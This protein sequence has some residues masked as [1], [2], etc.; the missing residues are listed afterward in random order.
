MNRNI[1]IVIADDH[2]IVR[3]GL[4]MML[5][6]DGTMDVVGEA[7]TG[8][9]AIELAQLHKPDVMTMDIGFPDMNGV[10]V[11]REILAHNPA[12]KII[13]LSMHADRYYVVEIIKAGAKAFLLKDCAFSELTAAIKSVIKGH[14][15]LCQA[16]TG[17]VVDDIIGGEKT[18]NTTTLSKLTERELLV[19]KR[20]TEGASA[21]EIGES[22]KVAHTTI[23]TYQ[24]RLK[25]KLGIFH[26]VELTK[27]AIRE[28][29]TPLDSKVSAPALHSP[30]FH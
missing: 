5:A 2:K 25:R 8:R 19:L 23:A 17:I 30:N 7:E 13:A 24:Q 18:G 26:I 1:S 22:L 10:T 21:K 9:R 28:G 15:Y 16:G 20:M 29:L 6:K 3:E 12:I 4:R 27:L 14:C 11:T